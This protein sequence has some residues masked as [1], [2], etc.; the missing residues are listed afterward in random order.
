MYCLLQFLCILAIFLA[1][2]RKLKRKGE[3]AEERERESERERKE[4]EREREENKRNI[5][6]LEEYDN[7]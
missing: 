6:K 5:L 2:R 7:A 4:R 1:L 3:L